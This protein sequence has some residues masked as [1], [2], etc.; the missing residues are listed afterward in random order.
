L[1]VG[2]V[3]MTK[4]FEWVDKLLFNKKE[5]TN[6]ETTKQSNQENTNQEEIKQEEQKPDEEIEEKI[7]DAKNE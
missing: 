7:E 5:K 1:I 6:T 2:G 4:A 3:F